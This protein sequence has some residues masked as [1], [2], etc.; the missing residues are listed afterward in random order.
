MVPLGLFIILW[1]CVMNQQS[2]DQIFQL[3]W[4]IEESKKV[5]PTFSDMCKHPLLWARF[6]AMEGKEKAEIQECI[7]EY[8]KM[9]IETLW[10]TKWGQLFQRFYESE[11]ELF[12]KF[13][14]LN[15]NEESVSSPEFQKIWKIVENEMFRLEW[16]LTDR[17]LKQEK[18]L[19]KVVDSFY[20]I[21]YEFF[22]RYN[23]VE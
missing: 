3:L 12:W 17:M 14:E 23:S 9:K 21:V 7:N 4:N 18:W 11:N 19:D 1:F 6:S 13:R 10:K 16:I 2:K 15:E 5:I 20:N 8:V 22:P